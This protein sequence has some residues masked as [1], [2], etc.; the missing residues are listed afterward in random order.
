MTP[1]ATYLG[2]VCTYYETWSIPSNDLGALFD[3]TTIFSEYLFNI[4]NVTLFNISIE[5]SNPEA[6]QERITAL[7]PADG[8]AS[9][10]PPIYPAKTPGPGETYE[11]IDWYERGRRVQKRP[12]FGHDTKTGKIFEPPP[13]RTVTMPV[14]IPVPLPAPVDWRQPFDLLT[15]F[16]NRLVED[17][18]NATWSLHRYQGINCS[19]PQTSLQRS[20]APYAFTV[21]PE[22]L[23]TIKAEFLMSSD[24]AHTS[25]MTLT[26]HHAM[27]DYLHPF[28]MVPC[29]DRSFECRSILEYVSK[30]HSN[31][32]STMRP[33]MFSGSLQCVLGVHRIPRRRRLR[34]MT[35]KFLLR[36]PSSGGRGVSNSQTIHS[37]HARILQNL[38]VPTTCSGTRSRSSPPPAQEWAC[39]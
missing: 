22:S 14:G 19:L 15:L 2:E 38:T 13:A 17:P 28:G 4:T 36:R 9:T 18:L 30:H 20:A 26:T 37:C 33:R 23:M 10:L 32:H 5:A 29:R 21:L 35:G 16:P 34:P 6:F 39:T 31:P 7:L 12:V 27:R 3:Y 8:S 25:C 1:G 11:T 24:R